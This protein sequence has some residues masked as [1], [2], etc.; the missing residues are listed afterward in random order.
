[1]ALGFSNDRHMD[2][3]DVVGCE[4]SDAVT[5][6]V[7]DTYNIQ[8]RTNTY[9]GTGMQ[10]AISNFSFDISGNNFSCTFDRA[11]LPPDLSRGF[12]LNVSSYFLFLATRRSGTSAANQGFGMHS[13]TPCISSDKVNLLDPS[14]VVSTSRDLTLVKTHGILMLSAWMVL[15]P[16]AIFMASYTKYIFPNGEWFHAH[17][18]LNI[19]AIVI[20]LLSIAI[21]FVS[22]GGWSRESDSNNIL[23]HQIAGLAVLFIMVLNPILALFRCSPKSQ[24]RCIFSIVHIVLGNVAVSLAKLTILFGLR[25]YYISLNKSFRES[26]AFWIFLGWVVIVLISDFLLPF[27]RSYLAKN[28][29][30]RQEDKLVKENSISEDYLFETLKHNFLCLPLFSPLSDRK[31]AEKEW[32]FIGTLLLAFIVFTLACFVA[33][34]LAI[35]LA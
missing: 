15:V 31:K 22:V 25:I 28:R 35:I 17:R 2:Y 18:I 3:S 5:A 26:I 9:D 16:I 7:K 4:K 11:F 13:Y 30:D 10:G 33:C 20:A 8:G 29:K 21:I 1:M 14:A 24:F 34:L 27:Y 32:P 6:N 23:V 12:S 19:S